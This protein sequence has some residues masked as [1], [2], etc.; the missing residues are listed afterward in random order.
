MKFIDIVKTHNG[1]SFGGFEFMF[2]LPFIFM[3]VIFTVVIVS[4]VK[5]SKKHKEKTMRMKQRAETE[6]A[7]V[8]EKYYQILSNDVELNKKR[9]SAVIASKVTTIC[10]IVGFLSFMF[11]P[12]VG[13]PLLLFG[14]IYGAIK[15][16]GYNKHYKELVLVPALKDYDSSLTYDPK[17]MISREDYAY[18]KFEYFDTYSSSDKID[19]NLNG[20]PFVMA[21]VHTQDRRTDSDGDTHYVTLFRGFVVIL[22]L[23]KRTGLDISIVDNRLKLFRGDTYV[24]ID[25]PEFE[26]FYDVFTTDKIKA[27]QILSPS[28]TNK[29]LDLHRKHD[30]YFEIKLIDNLL[31]LRFNTGTL[32]TPCASNPRQEATDIAIYFSLLNG[33]REALNEIVEATKVVK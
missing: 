21:N 19:G 17:G 8:I 5:G 20:M 23:Q 22:D 33:I 2:F 32:F 28:V 7:D 14:V 18:A 15:S 12:F 30:Y 6:Q 3:I 27:M 24:E 31:Y 13:M 11:M 10:V 29:I 9:K 1:S 16:S 26:E 4:V 25:N